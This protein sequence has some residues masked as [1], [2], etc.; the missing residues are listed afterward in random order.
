MEWHFPGFIAGGSQVSFHMLQYTSD[1]PIFAA[2]Y[3]WFADWMLTLSRDVVGERC[4]NELW[5]H[6]PGE[7]VTE[8]PDEDETSEEEM[9]EGPA[10]ETFA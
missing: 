4:T 7:D 1:I 6:L 9:G 10:V 5:T 8:K 2:H 3:R